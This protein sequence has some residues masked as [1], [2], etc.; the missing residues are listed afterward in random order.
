MVN[1]IKITTIRKIKYKVLR[2]K[3]RTLNVDSLLEDFLTCFECSS[4]E[5]WIA[6]KITKIKLTFKL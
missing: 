5:Y 6:L 4:L 2:E 1:I 3:D